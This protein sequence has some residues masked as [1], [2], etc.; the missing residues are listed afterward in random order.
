MEELS[1]CCGASRLFPESDLCS[2]CLEHAC[3]EE[4]EE[5]VSDFRNEQIKKFMKD[6]KAKH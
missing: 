5:E 3:F 2:D 4:E 6:W 1:N